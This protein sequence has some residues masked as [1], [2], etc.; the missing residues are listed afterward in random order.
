M[1]SSAIRNQRAVDDIAM[2]LDVYSENITSVIENTR[3]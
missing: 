3:G 1:H 2:A